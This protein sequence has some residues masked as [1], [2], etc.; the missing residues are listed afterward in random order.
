MGQYWGYIERPSAAHPFVIRDTYP[1]I[2]ALQ[3]ALRAAG[4]ESCNLILAIDFTKS[5]EET[6]TGSLFFPLDS[7]PAG[8]RTFAGHCLHLVSP[9]GLN[10]YQTAIKMVGHCLAPFD[11]D[12]L[13][14]T[15]GFGDI[16]T[17][18]RTVFWFEDNAEPCRGFERVLARYAEIAPYVQLSG[19]T[20]FAPAI[21]EALKIIKKSDGGFH[22][23]VIIADGQIMDNGETRKAIVEASEWP[24]AIIVVGVGDGP[25]EEME[26]FDDELPDRAFDNFNFV[27]FHSILTKYDG[28][29][30][31]FTTQAMAEVPTQFQEIRRLGLLG[32]TETPR[33]GRGRRIY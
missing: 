1:S 6:G 30:V 12:G 23:L 21:R 11:E 4:V 18:G 20:S 15:M 17:K 32:K 9:T 2:E 26:E 27:N 24:L 14:P 25:W 10:P 3:Q 33:G 5:N 13:I 28:D 7:C 31:A 22:I 29:L 8:K 19:P 16:R